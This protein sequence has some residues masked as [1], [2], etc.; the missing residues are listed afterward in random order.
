MLIG[1][2]TY[3]PIEQI[4]LKIYKLFINRNKLVE[5]NLLNNMWI[6]KDKSKNS[7]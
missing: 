6:D 4:I 2:G 3:K 5:I 1:F 7:K